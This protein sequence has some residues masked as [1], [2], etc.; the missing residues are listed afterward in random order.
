MLDVGL[1]VFVVLFSVFVV[2]QFCGLGVGAFAAAEVFLSEPVDGQI[3]I[4]SLCIMIGC[5]KRGCD[6]NVLLLGP[7]KVQIVLRKSR[8]LHLSFQ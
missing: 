7:W 2:E 6:P 1:L 4:P 3:D 8:L 5:L